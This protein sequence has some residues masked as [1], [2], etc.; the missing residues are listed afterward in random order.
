MAM[1]SVTLR[2]YRALLAVFVLSLVATTSFAA[3]AFTKI[4][5]FGDSLDDFGNMVQLTGGVFPNTP[6]YTYG[7][8]SNGPVWVEYFAARLKMSDKLVN[9]AVVGALTAPAP[10]FPT[11]NVWSDTFTGLEGT[12][13]TSQVQHYLTDAAGV[14]DPNALYILEG[15]S[16]DFPR[17][18]NPA[19]IVQN[20]ALCFAALEQHGAKHVLVVTLPDLGKT[21]RMYLAESTGAVPPG[22]A[23]FVSGVCAQLNQALVA[24]I[25]SITAADV[26]VTYADMYAFL[27]TIVAN[28]SNFGFVN[29]QLPYLLFG[30]GADPATWLFWDDVH[31][32]TRADQMF[33]ETAVSALIATYSPRNGQGNGPGLV[34]SLNG[35]VRR[36]GPKG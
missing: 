10:G 30:N 34:N 20:L 33:A 18:A 36:N 12:D 1:K 5:V 13:V 32:T 31:P 3:T 15:G 11:G 29:V 17:V 25:G 23:V 24:T 19:V 22:T 35:L 8:C 14:A 28:P 7:R 6:S 27:D 4:V 26:S 2:S 16:N 21:A 9:Y